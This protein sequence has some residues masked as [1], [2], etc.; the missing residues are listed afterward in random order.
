MPEYG[1]RTFL[2]QVA[3]GT[4][5]FAASRHNKAVAGTS[6]PNIVII[7]ADD[8]GWHDVGYHGSEIRTPKIDA[9]A[10]EGIE[11]DRFYVCPVCSPT[12]AGLMTGRYPHRFGLRRT[13]ISPLA[14]FRIVYG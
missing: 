12:R 3:A 4:A 7:V 14:G 11:L 2:K 5:C 6:K 13:V 1:R 10:R 9:L 8:L